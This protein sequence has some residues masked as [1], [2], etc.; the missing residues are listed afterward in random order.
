MKIRVFVAL[1]VVC[2]ATGAFASSFSDFVKAADHLELGQAKAAEN[3]S[4]S[5]GHLKLTLVSGSAAPVLAGNEPVG[6]YFSGKG[7]L[8]YETTETAELPL[9]AHNVRAIAHVKITA[10]ATHAI[11]SGDFTDALIVAGVVAMP[12]LPGAA[13]APLTDAFKEHNEIFD[14]LWISPRSH[15]L[16]VQKFSFPTNRYL[17]AEFGGGRDRLL[18][19]YDD[20]EDRGEGLYTVHPPFTSSG[21]RRI[22]Q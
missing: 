7:T 14:R 3:V 19:E 4:L 9:V 21:D 18:Y 16:A 2:T 17:R 6:L 8:D 5:I 20:I 11:L 10:D 12:Q 1:A 22:D 15:V 13:A